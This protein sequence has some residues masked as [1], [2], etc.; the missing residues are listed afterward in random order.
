MS[1]TVAKHVTLVGELSRLVSS[2]NLLELSEAEQQL[3]CQE[4]HYEIVQK[5][6]TFI[7]DMRVRSSDIIRLICLYALR[8][9]KSSSSEFSS[10]KTELLRRGGGLTENERDFMNKICSYGGSKFRE[11][12]LFS[13]QNPMAITKRILKGFKGVDNI[14][15]QHTPLVKD[16]VEQLIK[17]KLK[18]TSYPFIGGSRDRPQE[19]IV[20]TVGGITFEETLAIHNINKAYAGNIKVIIGG[21][22]VHNFRSFIDEVLTF[23][24]DG[25]GSVINESWRDPKQ[26]AF[27]KKSLAAAMKD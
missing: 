13:N 16:L 11:T 22:C 14:Y 7:R 25:T 4:D 3:A 5:I 17:G 19:I 12:D 9:E 20:F 1:G 26:N 10:L 6:R 2:L 24:S 27:V 8:Y 18:E 21:T 23:T 15:T